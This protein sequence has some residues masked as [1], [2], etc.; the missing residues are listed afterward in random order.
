MRDIIET[1]EIFAFKAEICGLNIV[2]EMCK[3]ARPNNSRCDCGLF[4]H[5]AQ[6]NLCRAAP[7]F[8][9]HLKQFGQCIIG[10]IRKISLRITPPFFRTRPRMNAFAGF[11]FPREK[12]T[13]QW[14]PNN[15]PQTFG[16]T[17]GNEFLLNIAHNKAVLRL[18]AHKARQAI[19]IANPQRFHQTPCLIVATGNIAHL[20][21]THQVVQSAKHF[22]YRCL[23]VNMV[24]IV[25]ID[26]IHAE[27]LQTIFNRLHDVKTRHTRVI[28]A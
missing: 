25:N 15:H 11:V 14:T 7:E 26:I 21:V 17:N 5:P 9:S 20:A 23:L 10:I 8:V 27:A 1:L 22:I 2:F 19:V 13:R 4:E 12:A 3:G 6:S 18:I 16:L 24:N 28:G